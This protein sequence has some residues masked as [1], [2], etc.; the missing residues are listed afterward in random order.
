MKK[1]HQHWAK[2]AIIILLGRQLWRQYSAIQ[3]A[4]LINS[5]RFE[6][7]NL[8]MQHPLTANDVSYIQPWMTF[9][10]ISMTFKV[11]TDYLQVQLHLSDPRYPHVSIS[12]YSKNQLTDPTNLTTET[13]RV[14]SDY[15]SGT[16]TSTISTPIH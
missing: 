14:V 15:L 12:R 11:P 13:Q 5:E 4:H 16:T 10:Y 9:D 1:I 2:I 3:R 6:L 8:R 7:D